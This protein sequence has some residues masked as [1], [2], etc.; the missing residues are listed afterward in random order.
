MNE[1]QE[2]IPELN[3]S[4]VIDMITKFMNGDKVVFQFEWPSDI[5]ED[6]YDTLLNTAFVGLKNFKITSVVA[7]PKKTSD[8]LSGLIAELT[9]MTDDEWNEVKDLEEKLAS[10]NI[11]R[12]NWVRETREDYLQ[13]KLIE[14]FLIDHYGKKEIISEDQYRCV[15]PSYGAALG[16][17][18]DKLPGE[19]VSVLDT[20]FIPVGAFSDTTDIDLF[21]ETGVITSDDG[22]IDVLDKKLKYDEQK[23]YQLEQKYIELSSELQSISHRVDQAF[24]VLHGKSHTQ[25]EYNSVFEK[26]KQLITDS[27]TTLIDLGYDSE[28]IQQFRAANRP[29]IP[30]GGLGD[31]REHPTGPDLK[32]K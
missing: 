1:E 14:K 6:K 22:F 25:E 27:F 4:T 20:L 29:Y 31:L 10:M 19:G 8:E 17:E 30:G 23:R 21:L 11:S 18:R 2:V 16:L 3:K 7:E 32:D 9:E 5:D 24:I 26:V 15:I 28:G 13:L 12:T